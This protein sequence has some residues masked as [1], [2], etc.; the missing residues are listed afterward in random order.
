MEQLTI[1][2]IIELA[3]QLKEKGMSEEDV[4]KVKIYLGDDEE[5]NGIHAG[6]YCN[7]FDNQDEDYYPE[8]KES[9]VEDLEDGE[10]VLL[11]S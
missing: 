7:T 4:S 5:L 10:I 11:L 3:K 9:L 2:D 1:G 8:Y 6:W